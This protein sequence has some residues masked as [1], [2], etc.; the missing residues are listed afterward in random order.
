MNDTWI[1]PDWPVPAH[2]RALTTTR[3]GGVSPGPY[4]SLNLADH[5]GDDPAAVATNRKRL[6]AAAGLPADPVWLQQVHGNTVV[7][8][9]RT[10]SVPEADAA[11]S[12]QPGQ[13]CAVLTADCLPLLL[14]DRAGEQ[15]AAVHAGWRGLAAGVIEK[16][17][18]ALQTPGG[19][20]LAW[21]GPAISAAAYTVGDDVRETFLAHDPRAAVAFQATRSDAWQ[22]DLY[23]LARQRLADS[24]VP[25]VH[26]G[27]HCT[28]REA[29][30]FY[31]YRRD[32]ATGRMATLIWLAP[33]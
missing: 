6:A 11:H 31:S 5:V 4:A 15:V 2:V 33:R 25:A 28:F 29:Q 12:H 24:G 3:A 13:V 26:G 17:V 32:G 20:L 23:Q 9:A 22:A 14:C 21:L 7:D 30:S 10:T 1:V 19:E 16:A 8:I 27:G 18:A